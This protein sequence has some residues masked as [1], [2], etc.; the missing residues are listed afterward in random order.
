MQ[1]CTKK[2]QRVELQKKADSRQQKAE[3]CIHPG[4][5]PGIHPDRLQTHRHDIH[6]SCTKLTSLNLPTRQPLNTSPPSSPSPSPSPSPFQPQ[7]HPHLHSHLPQI[8]IP[9]SSL[10][11]SIS[12]LHLHLPHLPRP[13]SPSPPKK[14]KLTKQSN[15]P[16]TFYLHSTLPNPSSSFLYPIRPST[17]LHPRTSPPHHRHHP[18]TSSSPSS[19]RLNVIIVMIIIGTRQNF[20]LLPFTF[21]P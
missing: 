13:S 9:I 18:A 1:L 19:P 21:Y 14:N 10:T 2:L 15:L 20:Y 6:S 17:I 16:A 5:R 12:S 11:S 7:P 3:S 4:I 8:S